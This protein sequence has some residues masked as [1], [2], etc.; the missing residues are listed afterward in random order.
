M[1]QP[2]RELDALVAQD[3]IG[4]DNM[5]FQCPDCGG[6]HFGT[7]SSGPIAVRVCHGP[8]AA[9]GWTGPAIEA[10]PAYSTDMVAAFEVVEN[11]QDDWHVFIGRVAPFACGDRTPGWNVQF[12]GEWKTGEH[13]R[14]MGEATAE[15]LPHAICLAALK[16][17]AT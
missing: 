1:M 2:G 3:V 17:V 15:I 6:H 9:C 13:L 10:P 12:A 4:V 16:A 11:M 5:D 8:P 14:E 7:D